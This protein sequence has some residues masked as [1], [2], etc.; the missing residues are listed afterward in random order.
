MALKERGGNL[1]LY[2]ESWI[3]ASWKADLVCIPKEPTEKV[4]L[5]ELIAPEMPRYLRSVDSVA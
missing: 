3:L 1:C 4:E 2:R 5:C